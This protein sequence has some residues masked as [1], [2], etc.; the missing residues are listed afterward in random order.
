MQSGV[1]GSK[2]R[3]Q[4]EAAGKTD[5][6]RTRRINQDAF[7]IAE[8][9][10]LAA[11]CD[12]MGGPVGGEIASKLAIESFAAIAR[13][14]IQSGRGASNGLTSRAL[15]RATAAANRA[16]RA[17]AEYE[18]RYRGMGT[19]LVAARLDGHELTVL[20]VGDS[21]AYLVRDGVARQVTKDHSY[22]A[23]QVR[24]GLMT[25]TEAERS[26]LQSVITR[27]I[28]IE[29]DVKPEFFAERVDAGD[30]LLLCSDGLTRHVQDEEI[31][32]VMGDGDLAAMCERLIALANERGGSD[33]ITCVVARFRQSTSEHKA[34]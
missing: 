13:Q 10:G 31:G 22:V 21:R 27:A 3:V 7:F 4:Y 33:N 20:N 2:L 1:K 26:P 28:G 23:E 18:T 6:G 15:C 5:V 12:G 29:D 34:G 32:R 24:A 8:D 25:E 17:R 9:L 14:E 19:T 16:V 30:L 11:V